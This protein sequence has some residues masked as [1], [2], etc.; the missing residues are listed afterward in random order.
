MSPKIIS[1]GDKN[2]QLWIIG[3]RYFTCQVDDR[4]YLVNQ[5]VTNLW[6]E[7]GVN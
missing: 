3:L 5:I 4:F 7:G 6:C 2:K 1:Y